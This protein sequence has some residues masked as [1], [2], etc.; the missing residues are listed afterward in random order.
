MNIILVVSDTLRRDHLPCYGNPTV[1]TPNLDAFAKKA[2]VFEDFYPASFPTVP[3]RA[4]LMTGRYTFTYLPWGPL[5]QNETTLA[6]SLNKAGYI[7]AAIADTPFLARNGY[8]HD[9]GFQEFIYVRGQLNGTQ[10][11]YL[12]LNR[13]ASEEL[14]YCAAQTLKGAADWLYRHHREKFFLYVDTWD[15]HEPW[16]PP[17]HYVK[18]Y[19]PDYAGEVIDPD[20][21]DY[22]EDG[23]SERDIQIAHACYCGEISMVDYWFGFLMERVRALNLLDDTAIIFTSDHGFYFGERGQ[24][25]KRRFRWPDGSTNE[26]GFAKGYTLANQVVYRSPLH[27]EITQVPL[28]IYLPGIQT[29]RL[30]GLVTIPDLMPTILEIAGA[31]IPARVQ[32]KSFLPL[33]NNEVS[34]IHDFIVTSAPY[35]EE[36]QLSKTVDDF[37]REV[38]EISPSSITDGQ[39]DLLYGV[40]GQPVELYRTKEDPGHLKNV[41]SEYGEVVERLHAQYIT[42]LEGLDT[43]EEY[44]APRRSI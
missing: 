6:Q 2:L 41:A 25:G 15:P 44:L 14:G 32:A 29:R 4:D 7:T 17:N 33:I 19:L 39:W 22:R 11:D 20:Y 3:A 10:R 5:P 40:S 30:P 26:E 13:P 28:L 23:L 37:E 35:E 21:W 42:W 1:I 36:G 34:S 24:F 9:R 16:D 38:L 31:D 18:P 43:S 27:N 12:R 8:G